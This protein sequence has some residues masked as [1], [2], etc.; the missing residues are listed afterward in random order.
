M[1]SISGPHHNLSD[2]YIEHL[3]LYA[4][5]HDIGKLNGYCIQALKCHLPEVNTIRDRFKDS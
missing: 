5:L 2:E 1:T 4:P 3:Y